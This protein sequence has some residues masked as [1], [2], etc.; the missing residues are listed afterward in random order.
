MSHQAAFTKLTSPYPGYINVAHDGD[1]V[2]IS[3][4]GD[5]QDGN[6][7]PLVKLPLTWGEWLEFLNEVRT[8]L[9]ATL[10]HLTAAATS[11]ATAAEARVAEL[12][13]E[14][15]LWAS[16]V[17]EGGVPRYTVAPGA[18]LNSVVT[19]TSAILRRADARAAL[20]TEKT[21]G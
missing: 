7:G 5:A 21:D 6:C 17:V 9:P 12:E 3:L 18:A 15:R 1:A 13:S 2:T 19:S 8:R 16:L 4:R 10:D 20:T 11:R 14:L